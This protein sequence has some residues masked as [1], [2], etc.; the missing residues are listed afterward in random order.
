[1]GLFRSEFLFM[2]RHDR[3]PDEH[4]Q[5]QAYR[6]AVE[7]HWQSMHDGGL[8]PSSLTGC[9]ENQAEGRRP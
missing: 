8:S 5:Y 6:A 4:E 2:G 3:L 1:M 7:G 9:G